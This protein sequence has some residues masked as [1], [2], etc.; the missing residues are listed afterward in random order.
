MI[1]T[2]L[3]NRYELLEK[4]GEGGMSVVYKAKCHKL[5]RYDAVKVLKKD[6]N[7]DVDV[8]EKFKREATAI[9]NLSDNNI[10]NIFDVGSQDDINYIVMEYVRGKTLKQIIVENTRLSYERTIDI[11]VQIARALD[12]AHRNNIIHRDI[13]PQNILVTD[14][15][16]VKVTDFGIAKASSSVTITNSN[17]IIGSA[18]YLSPEQ[19]R[20][21]FVDVRTD[22][23]SF[24]I[25]LYE[26]ITGK[27]PFDAESPVTIALKHI[28]DEPV[29]PKQ[30]NIAIPNSLNSLI[31]KAIQK[32]PNKRYQTIREML[33]DLLNIRQNL[34]YEV[35]MSNSDTDYTR[36]MS[37]D[38]VKRKMA[39]A[40]DTDEDD[41]FDE[42][43]DD[44]KTR[45]RKKSSGNGK[46][47]LLIAIAALFVILAGVAVGVLASGGI[48]SLFAGGGTG[49]T[50]NMK[51]EEVKVPDVIGL[52]QDDA[53]DKIESKGLVYVV[54]DE[55][56]SSKK[57]GTIIK[58][59]P[60]VGTKVKKNSEVGVR[61][62]SGPASQEVPEVKNYDLSQAETLITNSGFKV[63]K[64]EKEYSNV[65]ENRVIRQ[66]PNGGEE[67]QK[68]STVDLVVS[69]GPKIQT[70]VVPNL[71]NMTID[72]AEVK[73]EDAKLKI[74][75][76]PVEV[77]PSEEPDKVGKVF[78][79]SIDAN[80]KIEIG[81]TIKVKYGVA[82]KGYSAPNWENKTLASIKSQIR[83]YQKN[84]ITVNI[85]GDTTGNAVVQSVT[86]PSSTLYKGDSI[87]ITAKV[88]DTDQNPMQE[89]DAE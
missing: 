6:Y 68:G 78:E 12:C 29:P 74:V 22:I 3:N 39:D 65:K 71:V 48:G 60:D 15:G 89:D 11:G 7:N 25:V 79:Q 32:D 54:R 5:N 46:K 59:F 81:Q 9:A 20:G 73:V 58:T 55:V 72:A 41:I 57:K 75:K 66:T 70:T 4:I 45:G 37:T 56:N 40:A 51:N 18:H 69:L 38:D 61:V 16:V 26:M 36:V 80:T 10:V 23:Y 63:G 34:D 85:E 77:N 67:A 42:D 27:V 8:V 21:N 28:Q 52:S 50:D 86:A 82:E 2:M 31:L 30:L 44:V 64:V 13:K 88:P 1:G 33:N 19:A 53:K 35:K 84:G 14:E 49:I 24:G 43:D 83:Q 76:I 47:I 62:S 17:K 87:T